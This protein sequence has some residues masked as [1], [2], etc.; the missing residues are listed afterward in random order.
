M[1]NTGFLVYYGESLMNGDNIA[2]VLVCSTKNAKMKKKGKKSRKKVLIPQLYIF[3][4]FA[5]P[6][7]VIKAKKDDS[8]CGT[9]PFQHDNGCYVFV[10]QAPTKIHNKWYRG[11][12]IGGRENWQQGL[13]AACDWIH[14]KHKKG[15]I[16]RV[17]FGA[18]GDIA[19]IPYIVFW[20]LTSTSDTQ[21]NY[22]RE[23]NTCLGKK[24]KQFSMASVHTLGEL[25][26]A[27]S[28]GW[29]TFRIMLPGDR[30]LPSEILCPADKV[31][32]G[33]NPKSDCATCG[34]CNGNESPALRTKIGVCTYV[35]G[36]YYKVRRATKVIKERIANG[37]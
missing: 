25:A 35:H 34:M 8:I 37:H 13:D 14:E 17:R 18:Y 24:Y 7:E 1:A 30:P 28:M 31:T 23:W 36:T 33:K 22:T 10:G 16:I 26:R 19:S 29:K 27:S 6:V 2:A 3:S 11:G 12:Y 5:P 20:M 15:Y 32:Y 9:C 21:L 4:T